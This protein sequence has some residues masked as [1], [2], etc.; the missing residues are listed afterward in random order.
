MPD[1]NIEET[2]DSA[3][4][5][6]AATAP[7][8]GKKHQRSSIAFPYMDLE[9]AYALALAV[10]S[11]VGTGECA[12]DQLAAWIKQS[13]TSSAFR[14][15]L[16]AGRLFGLLETDRPDS[17]RLT[18]IGRLIVD[19]K[20]EREA[21]AR[22][23]LSVPLYRAVYDKFKGGV[24]PPGAARERELVALGVASTLKDR[25]RAVLERSAEQAGFFEH[26]KDRLVAPGIAPPDDAS[27]DQNQDT[28]ADVTVGNGGGGGGR[29]DGPGLNLDPLLIALL[30]KIPSKDE[31][32]PEN[33][34]LRWFRAFAMNVSQVFDEDMENPVELKIEV[35][36]D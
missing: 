1:E 24:V 19:A 7:P 14:L 5:R 23:F 6:E 34:R 30:Q 33:K 35:A 21:R 15:R 17:I 2:M 9:E 20:R 12:P 16:S 18:E 29:D 3:E 27:V 10:H 22:A 36:G 8:E 13:P 28:V 11:N 25:A 31:G 32:W 26:G 4:A